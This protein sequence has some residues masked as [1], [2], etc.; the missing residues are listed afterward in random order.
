MGNASDPESAESMLP[1]APIAKFYFSTLKVT[2]GR[3][4]MLKPA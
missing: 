2:L 4:P 1:L 3:V